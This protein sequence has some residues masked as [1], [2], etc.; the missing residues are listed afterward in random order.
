MQISKMTRHKT[1]RLLLE[2]GE[3]LV[4]GLNT[5]IQRVA[6]NLGREVQNLAANYGFEG[7]AVMHT[8]IGW[9]DASPYG[10]WLDDYQS[11][12]G[13]LPMRWLPVDAP[14]RTL[15][16]LIQRGR[17]R[18]HQTKFSTSMLRYSLSHR[19][20]RQP[21]DGDML[22]IADPFWRDGMV[23]QVINAKK[24]GAV[25]GIICYDLIPILLPECTL[26]DVTLRFRESLNKLIEIADFFIAISETVAGDLRRYSANL[27]G[28]QAADQM[29]I[30]S[31]P[32][33]SNACQHRTGSEHQIRPELRKFMTNQGDD[34]EIYLIVG[35]IEPRK[36]HNLVLDTFDK[37]WIQEPDLKLCF[38]GREGWLCQELLERIRQHPRINRNLL[39]LADA[40]DAELDYAYRHTN[41]LLMASKAEGFGLP[42]VEALHHGQTVLASD[43][44]IHREVGKG[45]CHYFSIERPDGLM[46]SIQTMRNGDQT[47][48]VK[49]SSPPP[50]LDWQ[51]SASEFLSICNRFQSERNR[52]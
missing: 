39:W 37:L 29:M 32:L 45:V 34:Q 10:C 35:T 20:D 30:A 27:I 36:N 50:L 1:A 24:E 9:C 4:S 43:I 25:T 38:I 46:E 12:H 42:L 5:G 28:Q 44:P 17:A 6:R 14:Y 23:K 8:P 31:F 11:V 41:T 47:T 52:P 15:R 49:P 51:S 13:T 26:P 7:Y 16:R 22:I 48:N 18:I 40:S 21:G 2:C 33:G 3:S 19:L